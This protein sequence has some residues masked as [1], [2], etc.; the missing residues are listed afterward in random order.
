[1]YKYEIETF[2]QDVIINVESPIVIRNVMEM[3]KTVNYLPPED[4][5]LKA[6][7]AYLI[8]LDGLV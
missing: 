6:I 4:L 8:T 1:M 7:S 3:L 2:L 5:F